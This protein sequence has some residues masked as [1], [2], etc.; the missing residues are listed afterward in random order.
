MKVCVGSHPVQARGAG[1]FSVTVI[2]HLSG[3]SRAYCPKRF[4]SGEDRTAD[5]IT[6]G[7]CARGDGSDSKK[8]KQRAARH[9]P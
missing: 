6:Q 3:G 9:R 7:G 8:G 4:S 2:E 5:G 1:Q